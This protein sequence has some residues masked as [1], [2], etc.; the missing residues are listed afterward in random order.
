[1]HHLARTLIVST[2]AGCVSASS[3]FAQSETPIEERLKLR[4]MITETPNT[5]VN[6]FHLATSK[7]QFAHWALVGG[8]TV[9]LMIYDEDIYAETAKVGHRWGLSN[10][11][12][13]RPYG[14]ITQDFA[15]MWG[16][17]DLSSGLY[18]L[19]DGWIHLGLATGLLATGYFGDRTRP[20][21]TAIEL[22]NGF[23]SSTIFE[24]TLKYSF[25]REAPAVR[26][27]R[28]GSWHP[29][30]GWSNYQSYRT[31]HDAFPSGHVMT[32][33]ITFTVLRANY[34]EW[35]S[36][37][38]PTQIVYTAALGF[39]MVN[40][41]IHWA[42]DYPLGIMLGYLFGK[43]AVKMAQPKKSEASVAKATALLDPSIVP[44]VDELT[45]QPLTNLRWDF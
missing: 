4:Q 24:Q 20:Y 28:G 18:F 12:E 22:F 36:W 30:D 2:L 27:S 10:D 25:G 37:L 26:E 15:L 7:D 16:P 13:L 39:G 42:G 1:M 33:T 5:Y 43:S 32:T 3:A 29:F 6:A 14:R 8:L 9:P 41:G 19:G 45:G 11:D 44:T 31:K 38:W 17:S 23:L 35:E 34:P 21:N 40:N